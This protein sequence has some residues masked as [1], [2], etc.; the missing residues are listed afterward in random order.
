[1]IGFR[2]DKG[3]RA[4]RGGAPHLVRCRARRRCLNGAWLACTG[5]S[6]ASLSILIAGRRLRTDRIPLRAT[7]GA[8]SV[9]EVRGDMP[10]RL[11]VRA[12]ALV[13]TAGIAVTALLAGPHGG[14]PAWGTGLVLSIVLLAV[15]AGAAL[16]VAEWKEA[17]RGHCPRRGQ[18]RHARAVISSRTHRPPRPCP[19]GSPRGRRPRRCGRCGSAS[20]LQ[21]K[22]SR[23]VLAQA[24]SHVGV[25]PREAMS[26]A[27]LD[28]WPGALF[29]VWRVADQAA[30]GDDRRNRHPRTGRRRTVA[31]RGAVSSGCSR[32]PR[33]K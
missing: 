18:A 10:M 9:I 12:G 29:R 14:I 23:G 20:P 16:N 1:M 32:M 22:T 4:R 19:T 3:T 24:F 6:P 26:R 13:V 30:G 7:S 25:E 27:A 28:G 5:T 2:W 8:M 33:S 15:A 17:Q 31:R 21:Y 11:I